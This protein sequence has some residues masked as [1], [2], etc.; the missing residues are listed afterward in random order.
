MTD[1]IGRIDAELGATREQGLF[2]AERNTPTLVVAYVGKQAD[3]V[4][5]NSNRSLDNIRD[6]I[7]TRYVMVDGRLFDIDTDM[8]EIGNAKVPA[9]TFYWRR[10]GN[11]GTASANHVHGQAQQPVGASLLAIGLFTTGIVREQARS[12]G[13][14]MRAVQNSRC[15]RP[16]N[17]RSRPTSFCHWSVHARP[18]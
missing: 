2:K 12:Y 1:T 15:A 4:V 7:D 8:A 17:G 14:S 11:A 9:P 13:D 5:L 10:N 18:S 6:I 3:L 16:I